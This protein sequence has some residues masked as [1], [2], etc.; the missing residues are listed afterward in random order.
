MK[1]RPWIG[2][3]KALFRK[4]RKRFRKQRM[5]W[6]GGI[7]YFSDNLQP[8]PGVRHVPKPSRPTLGLKALRG[9]GA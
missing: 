1:N 6:I 7:L 3:R 2:T 5:E 4:A 9:H 8:V